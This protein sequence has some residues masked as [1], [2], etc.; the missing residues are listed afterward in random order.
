LGIVYIHKQIER[1]NDTFENK[2]I[3]LKQMKESVEFKDLKWDK[4]I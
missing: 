2:R 4:R 1:I 3:N